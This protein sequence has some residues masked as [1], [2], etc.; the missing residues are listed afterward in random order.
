MFDFGQLPLVSGFLLGLASSL[1]CLGMCSGIAT[2]LCLAAQSL[3]RSRPGDLYVNNLVINTGRITGYMLA[4]ALVGTFGARAFSSLDRSIVYVVLRWGAAVALGWVGLSMSGLAPFPAGFYR[5][6][7]VASDGL[8][9]GARRL[10]LPPRV[11]FFAAGCLWGLFP[12]AMV[13]AALFYAMLTGSALSGALVMLGFGLGTLL[14]VAAAG[15]GLPLLRQRLGALRYRSIVGWAIM[16]LG[17]ATAAVPAARF[18]Q[19][20]HF[21]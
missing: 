1:H 4:G 3:P 10:R 12:C 18:A 9:G 14:P 13:Y 21:G 11:S 2:S 7:A 16:L 8:A 20:C 6:A 5:V 19:L 17:I 15:L